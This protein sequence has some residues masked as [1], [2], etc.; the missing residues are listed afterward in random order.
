MLNL[1]IN[2]EAIRGDVPI[3]LLT[4]NLT[5]WRY[6]AMANLSIPEK[7]LKKQDYI[8]LKFGR[9]LIT[10]ELEPYI[11]PKSHKK[12]PMVECRCD[13]GND[14]VVRLNALVSKN[15]QSCGCLATERQKEFATKHNYCGHLLYDVWSNMKDRC[16]NK[17]NRRYKHYG[18]KG[19]K[20]CKEWINDPKTF[21]EWALENDWYQGSYFDRE[22]NDG[23]YTPEN[24]RFVGIHKSNQNT[25]LLRSNNT[26]GFRGVCFDKARGLWHSRVGI[27]GKTI[28]LGRFVNVIDAAKACDDEII[29]SNGEQPLNFHGG[30]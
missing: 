17:N 2:N 14:L 25:S 10:K 4:D 9:L 27:N 29:K 11:D 3:P 1:G 8:G 18:G 24:C 6:E 22:S 30:F 13:C 7:K 5:Y 28:Y 23:D 21:I 16:Y 26:S 15:T 20:V 12:I 19:V